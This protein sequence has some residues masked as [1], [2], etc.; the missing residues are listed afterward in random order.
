MCPMGSSLRQVT[1]S[2]TFTVVVDGLNISELR[3]ITEPVGAD[4]AAVV[5]EGAIAADSALAR[6]PARLPAASSRA[7]TP[8]TSLWPTG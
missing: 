3:L 2:P 7:A 8:K 5:L 1:V 4:A 6:Q